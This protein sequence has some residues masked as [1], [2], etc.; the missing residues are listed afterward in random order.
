MQV[1]DHDPRRA[2]GSALRLMSDALWLRAR[3]AP[4]ARYERRQER[5]PIGRSNRVA[6]GRVG[7]ASLRF[8]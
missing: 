6:P 5:P 8:A 4:K 3:S 2:N 7:E 1:N